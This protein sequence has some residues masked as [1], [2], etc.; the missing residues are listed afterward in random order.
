MMSETILPDLEFENR[1]YELDRIANPAGPSLIVVD[2][3]PKYG[4][5]YLL[6]KVQGMYKY[7]EGEWARDWECVLINLADLQYENNR[8]AILEAISKPVAHKQMQG[9]TASELAEHIAGQPK[10]VL[11]L[12]DAADRREQE[13]RWLVHNVIP[14]LIA[15]LRIPGRRL[16][17]VF[18]GR[19]VSRR[20]WEWPNYKII[21]LTEFD[22]AIVLKMILKMIERLDPDQRPKMGPDDAERLAREVAFLS[23]GHPGSIRDILQDLQKRHWAIH[24]DSRGRIYPPTRRQ[25]LF[26]YADRNAKKIL[27]DVPSRIQEALKTLSIFRRFNVNTIK[28]LQ[29][30][31][32]ISGIS[33]SSNPLGLLTQLMN[34]GLVRGPVPR[35]PYYSDGIVRGLLLVQ[36]QFTDPQRYQ[37]LN[38]L[39]CEIYEAW[40]E[41]KDLDGNELRGPVLDEAQIAFMVESFYHFL[42][43]RDEGFS[44][45]EVEEKL[46]SYAPR[47][48]SAFGDSPE[49]I[50]GLKQQLGNSLCGDQDIRKRLRDL[51]GEDEAN[52]L[53][54]RVFHD[55]EQ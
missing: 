29:M 46:G 32:D 36:M 8:R 28:A 50:D 21:E 34:T 19:Y 15:S 12:F 45:G 39:A 30:R 25:G 42:H 4:K 51:F 49:L 6:E 37:A 14:E 10:N 2:A 52:A 33:R 48:K 23:G 5:T 3:P 9:E 31:E 40:A 13:T 26:D 22:E 47:L 18:A 44:L 17:V 41:S 1:E 53:L 27:E 55:R 43:C 16:R 24:F 7:R 20:G 38:Q 11:L 35:D 54:D